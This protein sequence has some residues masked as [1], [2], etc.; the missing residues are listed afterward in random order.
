MKK[1]LVTLILIF[2]FKTIL[3]Q[4]SDYLRKTYDIKR[5]YSR[6]ILMRV[7]SSIFFQY[8]YTPRNIKK[9]IYLNGIAVD[10]SGIELDNNL[11]FRDNN[12]YNT[13]THTTSDKTILY[14][15][16]LKGQLSN[17]MIFDNGVFI[18]KLEDY[19]L[20][21]IKGN[22]S[23]I[24]KVDFESGLL[25]P[26]V[27]IHHYYPYRDNLV[28]PKW[29]NLYLVNKNKLLVEYSE[30]EGGCY[31]FKYLIYNIQSGTHSEVKWIND[32]T[33][34]ERISLKMHES[35]YSES[36]CNLELVMTDLSGNYSYGYFE[37]VKTRKLNDDYVFDDNLN[38]ASSALKKASY[39]NT[40]NY[41][42]GKITSIMVHS[43]LDDEKKVFVPYK[44][45]LPLE[46]TYYRVFNSESIMPEDLTLFGEYEL[47][48]VKNFIFAKHNY[49]FDSEFY[50]AY[51]NLFE[52]YHSETK[53]KNRTKEINHLLTKS[54][55]ANLSLLNK[56]LKKY[57]K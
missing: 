28:L 1:K 11:V 37:D 18:N 8:D 14:R 57:S 15:L 24:F 33:E 27:K 2:F 32:L 7:D 34:A 38:I 5:K 25:S 10:S 29:D 46:R 53:R 52:F 21:H 43:I 35:K 16:T 50:Q 45:T 56:K 6:A 30:C 17:K 12:I 23:V 44:F 55:K 26:F 13:S 20:A 4:H 49:K 51:F 19:L 42:N 39:G 22:D 54:D 36:R 9:K 31:Y 47:S 40:Y 48:M 3:A 41:D